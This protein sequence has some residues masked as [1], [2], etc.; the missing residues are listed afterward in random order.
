MT[1][2]EVIVLLFTRY[3]EIIKNNREKMKSLNLSERCSSSNL[4][5][6]TQEVINNA[7][8]Y[9][10]DKLHRWLGFIQGVL[11]TTNIIDV[12]EERNFT[13]P[14]L[15]SYHEEKPKSFG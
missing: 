2:K 5:K 12:D 11:A 9:P 10:N 1:E 14:L 15:H 3:D 8:N 7:E 6:L 13:R 4:L